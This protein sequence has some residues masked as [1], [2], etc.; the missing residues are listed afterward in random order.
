MRK[1]DPALTP[2]A[3]VSTLIQLGADPAN[4]H[5]IIAYSGGV[6]SHVLLHL[7]AS[8]DLKFSVVHIN[9][10]ISA[11]ADAWQQ[12]CQ[13]VC[14]ALAVPLL[15]E[16]VSVDHD[17]GSL[18]A[19]ARRARYQCMAQHVSTEKHVLLTAHH[20][21][22][23]AETLLMRLL[24]G[25]GV[26]GW[27]GMRPARLFASGSLLRPLLGFSRQQL[28]DYA[29]AADLRW[30]EDESNVDSAHDRNYLRHEIM[31]LLE[32]RWPQASSRLALAA[33]DALEAAGLLDGLAYA[34]LG[35]CKN[36]EGE[37]EVGRLHE[38][39]R[40][41]QA[42]V[43][44]LWLRERGF[45]MPT[46]AKLDEIL[47]LTQGQSQTA[48][49]LC[50]WT[51]TEVWRY[52]D[53]L[54]LRAAVSLPQ[55]EWQQSWSPEGV[56][57]LPDLGLELVAETACDEG[58]AE[59]AISGKPLTLRLREGGERATLPG[60]D[61]R[62]AL[63]KLYQEAAVPPWLRDRLPLIYAGDELAAVAG[64]WVFE[65]FACKTGDKGIRIQVRETN[66]TGVWS[67]A[68]V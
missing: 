47:E 52:H 60:R 18:E 36:S 11:N 43:V 33:A 2:D 19:A 64:L 22:D 57:D 55:G 8:S 48:K 58:L 45:P 17:Q 67:N 13:Q 16:S 6:D 62:H 59:S 20:Q 35:R 26:H 65:P 37:I 23:Q 4:D 30:I 5:F 66:K 15:I 34:D 41:R 3:L 31:P 51:N 53:R 21:D 10:G 63:K 68:V 44:R 28:L 7:V 39:E 38:L 12:H 54:A 61:H 1:A 29:N 14:D 50:R 24:R 56:T 42:L 40:P 27:A 25:S 46:R 32:K 9:H 49:A